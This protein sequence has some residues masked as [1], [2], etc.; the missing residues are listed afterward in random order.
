[1]ERLK[2]IIIELKSFYQSPDTLTDKMDC[3]VLDCATRIFISENIAK[4]KN[5]GFKPKKE[6][7]IEGDG[8]SDKQKK[9]MDSL[10]LPL[11]DSTTKQ[12]ARKLIDEKLKD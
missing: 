7:K 9:F 8:A 1:M 3:K 2:E 11:N 4:E 12:E 10:N 6:I 5:G